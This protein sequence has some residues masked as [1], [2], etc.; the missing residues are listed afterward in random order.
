[1]RCAPARTPLPLPTPHPHLLHPREGLSPPPKPRP[2]ARHPPKLLLHA[3][4]PSQGAGGVGVDGGRRAARQVVG[5]GGVCAAACERRALRYPC[6]PR[7]ALPSLFHHTRKSLPPPPPPPLRPSVLVVGDPLPSD[8]VTGLSLW[9]VGRVHHLGGWVFVC[10]WGGGGTVGPLSLWPGGRVVPPPARDSCCHRQPATAGASPTRPP[11][12]TPLY[13]PA[14]TP[15]SAAA[16]P[17][18]CAH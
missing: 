12:L 11:P 5:S 13:P 18:P 4:P 3:P 7:T 9:Q 10:V 17:C 2:A 16:R 15:S 1:M 6:R 14:H 8:H